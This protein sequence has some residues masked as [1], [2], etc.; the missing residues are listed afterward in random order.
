MGGGDFADG[1]GI[2]F[3]RKSKL[4]MFFLIDSTICL[5]AD[6]VCGV[7]VCIV[8]CAHQHIARTVP[9]WSI[10]IAY[11]KHMFAQRLRTVTKRGALPSNHVSQCRAQC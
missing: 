3:E 11:A 8:V 5:Q 7:F 4:I 6:C 1:D 2:Q 9:E 10:I